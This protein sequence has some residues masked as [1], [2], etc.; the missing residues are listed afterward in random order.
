MTGVALFKEIYLRFS[1]SSEP[2][3]GVV[4][5]QDGELNESEGFRRLKHLISSLFIFDRLLQILS[6]EDYK[7]T[8]GER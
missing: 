6:K 8:E 4:Q 7:S 3:R 1:A 5:E 2:H